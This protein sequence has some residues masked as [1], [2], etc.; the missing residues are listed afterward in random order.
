MLGSRKAPLPFKG[1]ME[2]VNITRLR[3]VSSKNPDVILDYL[4]KALGY[5]V[6]IKGNP[7]FAQNKW[8]LWFVLPDNITLGKEVL[9][10]DLDKI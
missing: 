9:F 10:G 3:Y 5:K 4:N 7:T 8:F 1:F 6:E 2:N